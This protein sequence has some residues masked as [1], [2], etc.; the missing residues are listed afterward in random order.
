MSTLRQCLEALPHRDVRG[1]ATRLGIRRRGEHRKAD[2]IEGIV[3]TWLASAGQAQIIAG[4]SPAARQAA[5]R[6]AQGGEF[7]AQLFLA[8]YGAV[9][10]PR[11]A[12]RWL[13]PPWEAPQTISEELYYCGLLA[14]SPPALLEKAVRLTLPADLQ[15]L[16]TADA[17]LGCLPASPDDT[18]DTVAALLHDVAQALCFLIEQPG[19]T[20]LHGRWLAPAA[21]AAL[22]DRLLRPETWP[23]PGRRR[24][25]QPRSHARA[26]RLRF[27][28]FLATAAG[29]HS[30]GSLT[31]LGWTWLAEPPALRL[32]LLWNAW[33]AAPL[34]LRQ[35]YRQATAALPEPWPDL[36]LRHLAKLPPPITAV[37]LAQ[38]ILGQETAFTAY[39]TAHLPDISALD[40][41]TA[42]LIETLAKDWGA[43]A[44]AGS[45]DSSEP[46]KLTAVG[47]W[48]VDPAHGDLPARFFADDA[49][50][51]ARLSVQGDA[52]WQLTVS[53]W[54][55][56]LHLA[57]LA[58]YASHIAL[59]PA[60]AS[61]GQTRFRPEDQ[62]KETRS[63][64]I[65]PVADRSQGNGEG[66][67]VASRLDPPYHICRLDE[68]AVA[69]AAAAGHGL[70]ALVEALAGL[71]VQLSPAQLVTLQAWHARA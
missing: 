44:P 63:S 3:Q 18:G 47:R 48:L 68:A 45:A 66:E 49:A 19:L 4:L 37:R 11:P 27:L 25:P 33:C 53:P 46:F 61:F 41:A 9:R 12:Q 36:A 17:L 5:I 16:F 55:P 60:A 56:P 62:P 64:L 28:F 31:P 6:L 39:F 52:T 42:S 35:A 71:G 26:P 67:I 24:I 69:A 40:A 21:L 2:W 58:A 70:P 57:R 14:A 38:A 32:T 51:V 8:E 23:E 34:A 20:L 10:R 65:E 54:A 7:P 59:A 50:L 30:C 43:L 13:P 29:L 22:N 1:I 15:F